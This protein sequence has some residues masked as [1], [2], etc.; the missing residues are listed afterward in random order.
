MAALRG[1]GHF[2]VVE[3]LLALGL[4]VGRAGERTKI[5][6][7][8]VAAARL[9]GEEDP[10][11]ASLDQDQDQL[12][13]WLSQLADIL[14]LLADKV[15]YPHL[16]PLPILLPAL[17]PQS[18]LSLDDLRKTK[19]LTWLVQQHPLLA[20]SALRGLAGQVRVGVGAGGGA[21]SAMAPNALL[22]VLLQVVVCAGKLYPLLR[23]DAFILL[24]VTTYFPLPPLIILTYSFPV[25][26]ASIHLGERVKGDRP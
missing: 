15:R 2:R 26:I 20:L 8:L 12:L 10:S 18:E 6:L 11:K 3:A 4:Q 16:L 9:C 5:L 1:L 19:Y 13:D 17:L 24:A 22:S 14:H 7:L 23:P 21:A 25:A